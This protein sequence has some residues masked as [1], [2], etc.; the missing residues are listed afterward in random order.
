[1]SKVTANE[2]LFISPLHINQSTNFQDAILKD[3]STI[4]IS[5][6]YMYHI[7]FVFVETR[8]LSHLSGVPMVILHIRFW[9]LLIISYS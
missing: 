5:D 4:S 1:M 6:G 9:T 3:Y 2:T 8:T 7:T